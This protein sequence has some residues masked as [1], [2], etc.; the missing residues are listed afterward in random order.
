MEVKP[1]LLSG[2]AREEVWEK[3]KRPHKTTC[4]VTGMLKRGDLEPCS[5]VKYEKAGGERGLLL[6]GRNKIGM[7]S[8]R[9][10]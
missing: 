2:E 3:R 9:D 4:K 7:R 1:Q 10:C 6:V 8:V 5:L